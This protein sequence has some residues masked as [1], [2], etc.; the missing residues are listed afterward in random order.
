MLVTEAKVAAEKVKPI[1]TPQR[2]QWTGKK[3]KPGEA[4]F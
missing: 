4:P 2:R 3:L 1:T